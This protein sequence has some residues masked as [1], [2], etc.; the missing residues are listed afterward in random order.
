MN[1]I[2][3]NPAKLVESIFKAFAHPAR[4]EILEELRKGEFCVCH[5]EALLNA[6]Q[7]Y[8]SQQ[9]AVLRESGLISDRRDGW[10]VYYQIKD[11][12]VLDLLDTAYSITGRKP[13]VRKA[14]KGCPCPHCNQNFKKEMNDDECKNSRIRMCQLPEIGSA[15]QKSN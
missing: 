13:I 7:S 5:L 15:D 2:E 6:R 10:N 9:L 4:L 1:A 8:V 14:V 11:P 12:R 3:D